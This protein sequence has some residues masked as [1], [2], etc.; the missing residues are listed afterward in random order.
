MKQEASKPKGKKDKKRNSQVQST[1][2]VDQQLLDLNSSWD[3]S[4]QGATPATNL[5]TDM[6]QIL[7]PLKKVADENEDED[8][9]AEGQ[10]S[11]SSVPGPLAS[12]KP[13]SQEP[14]AASAADNTIPSEAGVKK[15][16]V[17]RLS[18]L[19][20][21]G[22]VYQQPSG[23]SD[24]LADT[25]PGRITSPLLELEKAPTTDYVN[26]DKIPQLPDYAN[27]DENLPNTNEDY[28]NLDAIHTSL[29]QSVDTTPL[30]AVTED[31]SQPLTSCQVL[32]SYQASD[33]TEVTITEGDVVT[34]VPRDDATPGW[35]M[36][37][38]VDGSEGWV[39]ESYLELPEGGA[40]SND[41][42]G[43][44]REATEKPLAE[45][46]TGQAS[47]HPTSPSNTGMR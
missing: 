21:K 27:V 3:N 37:R 28:V 35:T 32:Y 44:G 30:D 14:N 20:D 47:R 5:P 12:P 8:G 9:T 46:T 45:P 26:L 40:Q 36:V 25:R 19:F 41:Q 4:G 23:W 11:K 38:L 15:F 6:T 33:D 29:A 24:N 18:E 1:M 34:V 22:L 39:P 10:N 16:S 31:S 13:F 43:S 42:G 17:S 2:E 7:E